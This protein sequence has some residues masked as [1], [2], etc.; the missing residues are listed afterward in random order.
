MNG[1]EI[2]TYSSYYD[3]NQYLDPT[4]YFQVKEFACNDGSDAIFVSRELV[5]VLVR[6]RH[7]FTMKYPKKKIQ[8][9]ITSGYRT[10]SHSKAVGG[11]SYSNH[12]YGTAADFYITN[13]TSKEVQSVLESWYPHTYGIGAAKDYTHI[14]V[15]DVKGRWTY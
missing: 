15:R 7:H 5:D 13:V 10:A 12:L 8:C 9:I 14:D 3:G 4:H 1:K 6:V 11:A 2:L